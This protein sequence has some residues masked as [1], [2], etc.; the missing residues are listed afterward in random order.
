[1]KTTK[2]KRLARRIRAKHLS[3][4]WS[5]RLAA[6]VVLMIGVSLAANRYAV[7]GSSAS[8]D[9]NAA[10][11]AR[12]PRN[13]G[14]TPSAASIAPAR[15]ALPAA[16]IDTASPAAKAAAATSPVVTVT[17][18]LARDDER[19]QLKDATGADAPKSRSWKT[20]FLTKRTATIAITGVPNDPA[21][22]GHVGQRVSV[23]GVLVEHEMLVQSLKRV[24]DAC[25][26]ASKS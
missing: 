8:A 10:D 16:R 12:A 21:L 6:V 1:M 4:R 2:W 22:S 26:G 9:R 19:F 14:S 25:G 11:V 17:G 15:A 18:C 13:A 20:G 3:R 23:T 7:D 24:G 5:V